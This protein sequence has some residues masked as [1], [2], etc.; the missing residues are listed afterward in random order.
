MIPLER[1]VCS[2]AWARKLKKLGV[3]QQSAFYW[4][5]RVDPKT[6]Y[7]LEL[8]RNIH[9][10]LFLEQEFIAAFTCA[11]L[12]EM[13][14][15]GWEFIFYHTIRG[16][17]RIDCNFIPSVNEGRFLSNWFEADTE[18]DARAKMLCYLIENKIIT[19]E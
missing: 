8:G 1:Q 19:V 3:G 18:A 2:L 13:L 14:P 15:Q 9:S 17:H 5:Q 10:R 7:E 12:G 6:Q 16:P 11:E 4:C